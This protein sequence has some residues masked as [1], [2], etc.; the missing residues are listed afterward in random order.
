MVPARD[1]MSE[2]EGVTR[3]RMGALVVLGV[4]LLSIVTA[5][6]SG[7][8]DAFEQ[9]VL[10]TLDISVI[11]A[12]FASS[13][14]TVFARHWQVMALVI[15]LVLVSTGT[16][17]SAATQVSDLHIT[18]L[19]LVSLG[20]AIFMPW[21]WRWHLVLNAICVASFVFTEFINPGRP[22]HRADRLVDFATA[23]VVSQIGLVYAGRYRAKLVENMRALA[24]GE[25]KFH[26]IFQ[27]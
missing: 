21:N 12:V 13:S 24:E 2:L 26:R 17:V 10:Y 1:A 16:R 20:F 18:T 3:T 22:A 14:T 4:L 25:E 5:F 9:F 7:N 27:H 8:P 19:V 23:L 6:A 15:A 11:L